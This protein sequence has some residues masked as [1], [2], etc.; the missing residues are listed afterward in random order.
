MRIICLLLL[1]AQW[2]FAQVAVKRSAHLMGGRFEITLVAADSSKAN[3]H[4]DEVIAEIS[5][6]E[7]L[8]S[9]WKPESQVSRVNQ[10][11]GITPVKVDWEVFELTRRAIELS[12]ITDGAFD[13]SFA[14]MEKV[15]KFDG[16]M[17]EVPSAQDIRKSVQNVGYKNIVLD[18]VNQTIFLRKSGMKIG[19]GALGEGY[20]VDRCRAL[21]QERGIHAGLINATGDMTAWGNRPK[22]RRGWPIGIA[23]PFRPGRVIKKIW[24]KE[25]VA[26]SGS[27]EK[28]AE[29]DGVR[30]SHI[31]NPKTGYP[32]TGLISVTVTGPSAEVANGLSTSIMVMGV[33]NG[34]NLLSKFPG[35]RALLITDKGKILRF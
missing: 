20:A 31:I 7:H 24:L 29:L 10:N 23:D 12:Q 16:S 13:I 18:S 21:M 2:G 26:T 1:I 15:W 17:T 34:K 9:D 6:I 28:F 8:I 25:S 4:I 27:Y 33:T 30:Y 11:A 14:A 3:A 5:R 35:Y 22:T 32:A 19:F